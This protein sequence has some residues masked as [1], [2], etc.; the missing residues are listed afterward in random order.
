MPGWNDSLIAHVFLGPVGLTMCPRWLTA[1][2]LK[3]NP[4]FC[5]NSRAGPSKGP[6]TMVD[7]EG[8]PAQNSL[9]HGVADTL[10]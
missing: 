1:E 4:N 2:V 10:A 6:E 5:H 9:P 3:Q 8:R 7:R